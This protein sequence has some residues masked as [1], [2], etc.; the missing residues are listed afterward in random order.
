[1]MKHYTL[2]ALSN[3]IYNIHIF[4]SSFTFAI[5]TECRWAAHFVMIRER[6][7]ER[8]LCAIRWRWWDD[9]R[10]YWD[11]HLCS[12]FACAI[13]RRRLLD[14]SHYALPRPSSSRRYLWHYFY[15][16]SICICFTYSFI[17]QGLAISRTI[18]VSHSAVYYIL[19]AGAFESVCASIRWCYVAFICHIMFFFII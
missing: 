17:A 10:R 5:I 12:L 1:M 4:P 13:L 6:V 9:D 8:T 16:A 11:C 14:M 7:R 3:T 2:Y 19:G 15:A 18:L